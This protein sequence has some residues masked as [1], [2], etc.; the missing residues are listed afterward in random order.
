MILEFHSSNQNN[1]LGKSQ[2]TQHLLFAVS[3]IAPRAD[4]KDANHL[5]LLDQLPPFWVNPQLILSEYTVHL[6]LRYK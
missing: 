1:P 5:S 2:D 6:L 3:L 4:S